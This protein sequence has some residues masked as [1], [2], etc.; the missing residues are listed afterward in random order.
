MLGILNFLL[1]YILMPIGVILGAVVV[2]NGAILAVQV[3]IGIPVVIL[4]Y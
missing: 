1:M 3:I 4:R 2:I